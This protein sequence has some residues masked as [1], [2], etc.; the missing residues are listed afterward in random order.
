MIVHLPQSAQFTGQLIWKRPNC[1]HEEMLDLDAIHADTLEGEVARIESVPCLECKDV[2]ECD[3]ADQQ[4]E[5]EA[6]NLA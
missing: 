6:L 5:I 3:K 1:G 4:R 2:N